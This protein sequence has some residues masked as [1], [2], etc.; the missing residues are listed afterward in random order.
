MQDV[1]AALLR[2]GLAFNGYFDTTRPAVL[3]DAHAVRV[4]YETYVFADL[5]ACEAFRRDMV[6]FCGLVTD[7]VTK[8]RF[9]P[10]ER[11]PQYVDAESGVTYFFESGAGRDMFARRPE[12]YRLPGYSM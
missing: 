5:A 7:P 8:R 11:S 3:D 6:R 9:R 10:D 12:A 2:K 1:P 4:N